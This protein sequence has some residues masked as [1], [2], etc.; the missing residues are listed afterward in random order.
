[1][2]MSLGSKGYKSEIN[3]T[4]YIDILLV[5]LIIF[6]VATPMRKFKEDVRVPQP[7]PVQVQKDVKQD[8]VILEVDLNHD[9]RINN[10]PVTLDNL[11]NTLFAIFRGRVNKNMF[12]R[13]DEGLDYGYVFHILDIAKQSG[14]GDIALLGK[15]PLGSASPVQGSPGT[16][17]QT[18]SVR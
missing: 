6:F 17:T 18:A 12:I 10:Q 15:K 7:A 1:M 14:V 16:A 11:Q 5:L 3:I 4:P 8:S 9:I 13:G 2:S